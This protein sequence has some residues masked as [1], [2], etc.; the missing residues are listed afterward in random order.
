VEQIA[1][2]NHAGVEV[3]FV[4]SGAVGMGR[5]LLRKQ[6]RLN[7]SF[8]DLHKT[9]GLPQADE[10][11]SRLTQS[12]SINDLLEVNEQMESSAAK[13]Y[14]AAGQFELMNL[15]QSLFAPKNVTASQMLVRELKETIL[16]HSRLNI[17]THFYLF[18]LTAYTSRL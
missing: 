5:N 15:Y 7:M 16:C 12:S 4:S 3:L 14:A 17:V 1:E 13:S 9:D 2:L 18:S 11:S 8:M 10:V 6:A